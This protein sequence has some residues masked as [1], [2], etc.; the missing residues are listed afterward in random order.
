MVESAADE[1][2]RDLNSELARKARLEADLLEEQ[3]TPR[4]RHAEKLKIVAGASGLVLAL[5][6]LIGGMLSVAG[7]FVNQVENRNLQIEERLDRSL[8][9]LSADKPTQR[10]AAVSSLKSFLD[11]RSESRNTRV[12]VSVANAIAL[13]TDPVVRNSM[14]AFFTD[15]DTSIVNLRSQTEGLTTLIKNNRGI[16]RDKKLWLEPPGNWYLFA[17]STFE[18]QRL[19][20]LMLTIVA[21]L[22]HGARVHDT[23]E[24]YLV[25]ADFS[26]LDLS[27]TKFDDAFLN[28]SNFAG[29]T[30]RRA[31]FDGANLASTYFTGA[32]LQEAKLTFT[33]PQR[34]GPR[35]FSFIEL[36]LANHNDVQMPDFDCADLRRADFSGF[37]L[38][39]VTSD[40]VLKEKNTRNW[41]RFEGT[42]L[43]GANFERAGVF[44]LENDNANRLFGF[45][46]LNGQKKSDDPFMTMMGAL[47]PDSR[48]AGSPSDFTQAISLFRFAFSSANSASAR[49]PAG[50]RPLLGPGAPHVPQVLISGCKPRAPW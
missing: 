13:E 2:K 8:G 30:L 43:E 35:R 49:L 48:V 28:W 27:D 31:T 36:S 41:I 38:W 47:E 10:V 15:L 22:R 33:K 7:W 50:V 3:F 12:V 46:A 23:S 24:L 42:N 6:S 19:E 5:I 17:T 11:T 29:S 45:Q 34:L 39:D 40:A 14:I 1:S 16:I 18:G 9:Q 25:L 20:A 32:D 26:G 44:F 4:Y 21:L 37:P